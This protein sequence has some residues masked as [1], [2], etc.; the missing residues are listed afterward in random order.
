MLGQF[1]FHSDAPVTV[2]GVGQERRI[3]ASGGGLMVCEIRFEDGCGGGPLHTHP[4][5]QVSYVSSGE[6][7]Y[8]V[9]EETKTL[10][11]GDAVMV[12]PD[13]PHGCACIKAGVLIDVFTPE[14]Q[15][16]LK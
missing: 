12:E 15:D 14:R 1:Q 13:V 4:H 10:K 5:R 11:A 7:T 8:T 6:F 3:L 9:G 16:F 2:C